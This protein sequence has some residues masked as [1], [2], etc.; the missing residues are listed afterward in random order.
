MRHRH[1][2]KLLG[3]SYEHRKALYRNLM[4][5]LLQ[6]RKITTTIAKAKAVQPEM[7]RLITIAREDTPHTRRM[8]LSKLASKDAM[9]LAFTFL[10]QDYAGRNGGYTRITKLGPRQGDGA[11]MAVLELV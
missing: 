6:H 2:G 3:R 9:R 5:A 1:V 8:V 10:P 4:I 7:E 11:E